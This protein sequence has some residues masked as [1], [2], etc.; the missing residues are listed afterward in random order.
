[1]HVAISILLVF[2]FFLLSSVTISWIILSHSIYTREL[3][4]P[5]E[6]Y[7]LSGKDYI[8]ANIPI[9]GNA[10]KVKDEVAESLRS[11]LVKTGKFLDLVGVE[12]WITGGT[13]LGVERHAVVLM[14][15]DDDMDIA[16]KFENREYIFSDEFAA[17]AL[18]HN[19]DMF[20]L[21]TN[22][23]KSADRH[24]GVVRVQHFGGDESNRFE[25][26]D[27]FV[28]KETAGDNNKVCKLNGWRRDG[29]V[30]ENTN[31]TFNKSDLFPI[32]RITC[33]GVEVCV[34]QHPRA[35]LEKQ[36]STSVFD[37]IRPRPLLISHA[38]PIRFLNLLFVRG[39]LRRR[40]FLT[41]STKVEVNIT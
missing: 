7:K 8:L 2:L 25:S 30:I 31:E 38:F 14:P 39:S 26:L 23:S 9:E 17:E 10:Y 34:P 33:D 13:L 41:Q 22:T 12:W 24:G 37:S 20:T 5:G 4:K 40:K 27:I 21:V 28:W 19:L 35:L 16:V 36:Y 11:L 6:P 32:R 29:S 15:W 3:L 1:M 18:K